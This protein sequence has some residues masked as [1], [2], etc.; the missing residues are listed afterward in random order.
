MFIYVRID[1]LPPSSQACG[2]LTLIFPTVLRADL[3]GVCATELGAKLQFCR[4]A[5]QNAKQ[6]A[7][8]TADRP[9]LKKKAKSKKCWSISMRRMPVLTVGPF[10][11][12]VRRAS[13]HCYR[14]DFLFPWNASANARPP[15]LSWWQT[16]GDDNLP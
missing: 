13:R 10:P 5:A 4:I 1:L 8:G 7:S 3:R 2:S 15:C 9:T 12:V 16:E 6:H 11:L 14:D